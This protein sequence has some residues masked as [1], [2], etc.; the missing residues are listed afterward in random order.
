MRFTNSRY[1]LTDTITCLTN[2]DTSLRFSAHRYNPLQ[3]VNTDLCGDQGD[4]PVTTFFDSSYSARFV[5]GDFKDLGFEA[6]MNAGEWPLHYTFW[7]TKCHNMLTNEYWW[8]VLVDDW[9]G[10]LNAAGQFTSK[11]ELSSKLPPIVQYFLKTD[12]KQKQPNNFLLTFIWTVGTPIKTFLLS[13]FLSYLSIDAF[14]SSNS[15]HFSEPFVP[16]CPLSAEERI[17][18]VNGPDVRLSSRDISPRNRGHYQPNIACTWT[19]NSS[20]CKVILRSRS[21]A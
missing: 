10:I 17:I 2:Q 21:I 1:N 18:Y 7:S 9:I 4:L 8:D 13:V 11:V 16:T 19:I 3:L 20:K 12:N 15:F 5:F 14:P 6:C